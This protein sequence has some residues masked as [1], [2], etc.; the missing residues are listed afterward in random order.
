MLIT[1]KK[2]GF[3]K[4]EIKYTG[5]ILNLPSRVA[6]LAPT[7]SKEDLQV[8]ISLF[9]YM[10]YF[11]NFENAI[12][13]L[14]E[15]LTVSCEDVKSSLQF[16]AKAGVLAID[17]IS[18]FESKMVTETSQNGVPSYTGNQIQAYIEKNKKMGELFEEC[19]SVLGKT[20]NKHDYDN[21]IYLKETYKFSSAYML[22]LL[23][24]CVDIGKPNWA[25]IRKLASEFYDNGISTYNKLEKHFAD[26]KNEKTLEYKIRN[27][28]GIGE[29]EFIKT[30]RTV[31]EKWI[32]LGL[33]FELI[34]LAYEITVEKTQKS[35]PR[36]ADK[37]IDNWLSNG[38]KTV[39]D[40]E[41]AQSQY[42]SKQQAET[43]DADDFF[44]AALKRSYEDKG[45][46]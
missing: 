30:E 14:A 20:F 45:D 31:F 44:E 43:F 9:G 17:G 4:L 42:K 12:P 37:I 18:D 29:R 13:Q 26:R 2:R 23:A 34:K 6:D 24:H 15:K 19:Q 7:V 10:E 36:Y 41:N 8:I 38:I 46:E 3:M 27:L 16:W 39:E 32:A 25:Y 35:S 11:S 1:I 28:F 33:D 40:A 5:S 22:L 21:V